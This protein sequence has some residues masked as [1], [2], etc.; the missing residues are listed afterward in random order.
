MNKKDQKW[1]L[2]T[3]D[4]YAGRIMNSVRNLARIITD[5]NKDVRS[6]E[7]RILRLEEQMDEIKTYPTNNKLKL[8]KRLDAPKKEKNE[9]TAGS[10]TGEIVGKTY[11]EKIP[12]AIQ[13]FGPLQIKKLADLV[14]A[15]STN[16]LTSTLARLSKA[17][18]I[19]RVKRGIYALVEKN[20]L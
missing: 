6:Y 17:N 12:T 9:E 14:G 10:I 20:G 7:E 1:V 4:I 18:I 3:I 8:L 19:H 15:D 13:T 16:S 11:Y 2:D 5:H